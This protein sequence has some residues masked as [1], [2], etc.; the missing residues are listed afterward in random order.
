MKHLIKLLCMAVMTVMFVSCDDDNYGDVTTLYEKNYELHVG[1]STEIKGKEVDYLFW[2][3][4]NDFVA[5]ATDGIITGHH[6][7]NATMT[8]Y[9]GFKIYIKVLPI[10]RNAVIGTWDATDVKV[11]GL[12]VDIKDYPNLYLSATFNSDGTFSGSGALGTGNG[13]YTVGNETIKT[14]VNDKLFAIYTVKKLSGKYAEVTITIDGE[15]LD[16]K[17]A[18][19]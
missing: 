12:W 19:R 1:E 9:Y 2:T 10:D 3:S 11:D 7:G 15:S 14:Y 5:T 13:T 4:D 8:S 17:I 18:K 6:V 16:L